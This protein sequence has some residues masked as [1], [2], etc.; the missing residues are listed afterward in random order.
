[1]SWNHRKQFIYTYNR[2][3]HAFRNWCHSLN[4]FNWLTIFDE[5][6]DFHCIISRSRR[7]NPNCSGPDESAERWTLK[8]MTCAEILSFFQI[9]SQI[10]ISS[11]LILKFGVMFHSWRNRFMN[12]VHKIVHYL[13]KPDNNTLFRLHTFAYST[14]KI[15]LLRCVLR[16]KFTQFYSTCVYNT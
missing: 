10:F 14:R 16:F 4:S 9:M 5:C 8:R 15:H 7:M 6:D 13:I 3:I 1:M 12:F 2:V 11:V